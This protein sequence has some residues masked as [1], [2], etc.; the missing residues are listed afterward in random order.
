MLET[1]YKKRQI[2]EMMSP[3]LR[4]LDESISSY[5]RAKNKSAYIRETGRSD[6]MKIEEFRKVSMRLDIE[7]KHRILTF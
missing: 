3:E 2:Y 4:D 6:L 1:V 5:G 7:R